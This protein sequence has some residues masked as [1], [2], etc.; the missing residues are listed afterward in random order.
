MTVAL[1]HA[2][3]L[4]G[5]ALVVLTRPFGIWLGCEVREH[6]ECIVRPLIITSVWC[7][8]SL[9]T[10]QDGIACLG[11]SLGHDI[12][13][14][15]VETTPLVD[16]PADA[17]SSESVPSFPLIDPH[18]PSVVKDKGPSSSSTFVPL[19][20]TLQVDRQD[21][22]RLSWRGMLCQLEDGQG[23]VLAYGRI[24]AS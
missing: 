8:T 22:S 15:Y 12:L 3:Y 4:V 13:W 14:R 19:D 9:Q 16:V 17:S 23:L 24:Q 20:R 5:T 18:E 7:P 21:L 6:A 2:G 1:H 10:P 11:D